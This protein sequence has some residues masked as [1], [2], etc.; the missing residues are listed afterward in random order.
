MTRLVRR[1]IQVTA[2]NQPEAP[3]VFQDRGDRHRVFE[4]I[5]SWREAGAW[6]EGER[7]YQMWRV[8]TDKGAIFDLE[9]SGEEWF[10]YRV[11][12]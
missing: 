7:G 10:I 8:R 11:W 3:I 4:V 12:D 6:W 1:A 2:G 5:D 9:R